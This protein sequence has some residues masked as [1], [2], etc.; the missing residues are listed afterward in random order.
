MSWI[1]VDTGLR[2]HEKIWDLADELDTDVPSALGYMICLWSWALEK[3]A[4]EQGFIVKNPKTIA[5]ASQYTG[6]P[7]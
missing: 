3:N 6:N 5:R 2:T 7:N 4:D 1:K